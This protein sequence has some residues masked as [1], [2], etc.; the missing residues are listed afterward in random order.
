MT[1]RDTSSSSSA[2][3]LPAVTTPQETMLGVGSV[4]PARPGGPIPLTA[5]QEQAAKDWAADDRLWTTQETVEF[6]LRVFART[7]L[8]LA[9]PVRAPHQAENDDHDT[10]VEKGIGCSSTGSTAPTNEPKVTT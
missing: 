2:S 6:N 4:K 5:A 8:M 7:I 1:T 3:P 9:A 10:R